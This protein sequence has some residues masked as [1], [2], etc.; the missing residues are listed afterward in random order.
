MLGSNA[1]GCLFSYRTRALI[2]FVALEVKLQFLLATTSGKLQ[3]IN[4]NDGTQFSPFFFSFST[5][6]TYLH[7][8]ASEVCSFRTW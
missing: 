4:R 6:Y 2:A 7:I 3:S 1:V 5:N 8:D